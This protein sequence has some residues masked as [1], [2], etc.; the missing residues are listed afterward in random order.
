MQRRAK[1]HRWRLLLILNALAAR[2]ERYAPGK[3]SLPGTK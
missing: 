1:A 2:A 3:P